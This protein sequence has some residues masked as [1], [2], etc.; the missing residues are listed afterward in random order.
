MG[1]PNGKRAGF[2]TSFSTVPVGP[3]QRACRDP[4]SNFPFGSDL[5][6]LSTARSNSAVFKTGGTPYLRFLDLACESDW[7]FAGK[8]DP[9]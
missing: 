1:K 9:V 3:G 8:D 5:Q 6:V 2:I 4:R 7:V